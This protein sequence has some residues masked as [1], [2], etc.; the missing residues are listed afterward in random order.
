MKP[1]YSFMINEAITWHVKANFRFRSKTI[2][3]VSDGVLVYTLNRVGNLN[4][5]T[6][7]K[8]RV[9]HKL[10]TRTWSTALKDWYGQP[11]YQVHISGQTKKLT[12][13][14]IIF[15]GQHTRSLRLF[16]IRDAAS[17]DAQNPKLLNITSNLIRYNLKTD[18]RWEYE[19]RKKKLHFLS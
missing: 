17:L 5:N 1:S 19:I 18:L 9:Y 13:H 6:I 3:Q 7:C 15:I 11:D 16:E 10:C 2:K 14:F 8:R 12:C 4:H